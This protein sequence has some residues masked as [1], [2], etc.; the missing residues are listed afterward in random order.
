MIGYEL[1]F[2]FV[3]VVIRRMA[4]VALTVSN[5]A[6]FCGRFKVPSMVTMK[7]TVFCLMTRCGFVAIII[8]II[9]CK[10]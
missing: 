6:V 5:I 2:D 10:G 1:Y 8:I 7:V 3:D 9:I 4:G